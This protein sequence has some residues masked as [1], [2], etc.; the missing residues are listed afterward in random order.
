M[1]ELSLRT[2]AHVRNTTVIQ[3]ARAKDTDTTWLILSDVAGLVVLTLHVR[4]DR[5][6]SRLIRGLEAL[7]DLQSQPT[8]SRSLE[9]TI[10]SENVQD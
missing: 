4:D 5:D 7:R 8:P 9:V 10:T 6:I 3:A 1:I 2:S